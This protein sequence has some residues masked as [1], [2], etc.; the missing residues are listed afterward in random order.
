MIFRL[1]PGLVEGFVVVSGVVNGEGFT[2]LVVVAPENQP[3]AVLAF[4][5]HEQAGVF[6]LETG[7][8][9]RVDD[10]NHVSDGVP[11]FLDAGV[12]LP[13]NFHAHGHHGLDAAPA[14]AVRAWI[15]NGFPEALVEPLARHFHH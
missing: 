10:D 7:E 15:M 11:V 12:N 5:F 8:H 6:I 9:F 1:L 3:S 13:L 4:Q 14:S 2:V